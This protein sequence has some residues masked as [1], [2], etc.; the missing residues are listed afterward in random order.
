VNLF[1]YPAFRDG[2]AHPLFAGR[3]ALGPKVDGLRSVEEIVATVAKWAAQNPGDWIVG[4]AYDRSLEPTF[5]ASW[6]DA[7]VPNRP[8]VL[9]ASDH[10]TIW[11]NTEA[12]RRAGAVER[13]PEVAIG[14]ADL[15]DQ[16]RPSGT[17]RESGAM[18]VVLGVIPPLSV[19]QELNALDWAQQRMLSVGITQVQDAWIERGMAEI[20]LEALD[21]GRLTVATNLAFR[22]TPENFEKDFDYFEGLRREIVTRNNPLLTA[23]TAKFFADGVFGSGTAAVLEPYL[24]GG[25]GEPVWSKPLL[26]QATRKYAASGYQLHIH[27]IGDAAVRS[28][29]DAIQA[30]STGP[31]PSVITHAELVNPLDIPRFAASR[32]IANFQPFWAKPDSM[33]KSCHRW[34]GSERLEQLYAHRSF[35]DAGVQISFGS[36]WPVSTQNPLL[37]IRTAITR[38]HEGEI[39]AS[40]QRMSVSEALHAYTT[41][42]TTQLG[43]SIA[44]EFVWLD[45]DLLT[46]ASDEIGSI[47]VKAVTRGG[48]TLWE[49]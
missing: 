29:L 32:V 40:N 47:Q 31:L 36:D 9:H 18:E 10:H 24:D 27:A 33:L 34:L 35:L 11:V 7:A 48:E 39:L 12:L 6:L 45:S 42:V 15:D 20:Y 46:T 4:G 41:A 5:L 37:G 38:E 21:S 16:G 2:H 3:E 28:S 8:V 17:L 14:H 1:K 22:I 49:M 13:I 43:G 23:K 30:A 44:D 25:H 26:L 19:E